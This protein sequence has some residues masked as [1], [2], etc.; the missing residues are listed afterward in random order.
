MCSGSGQR[1]RTFWAPRDSVAI[2]DY[3]WKQVLGPEDPNIVTPS[4]I[5]YSTLTKCPGLLFRNED[6]STSVCVTFF[7]RCWPSSRVPGLDLVKLVSLSSVL[8]QS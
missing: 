2:R 4:S 5:L 8:F 3:G 7:V 1:S 6:S